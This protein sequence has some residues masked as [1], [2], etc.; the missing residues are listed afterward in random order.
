MEMHISDIIAIFLSGLGLLICFAVGFQL[1]FRKEG[2]RQTNLFLGLLLVLLAF[3]TTNGL[4]ATTGIMSTYR[5]LYF[6]PLVFTWS[7]G[8]L[9]YFFVRSKINPSFE[10]KRR[11]WIHFI[12]PMIQF[13]FY[14]SIGF[15]SYE[16]KSHIWSTLISPYL[17]FVEEGFLILLSMGYIIAIMRHLKHE[18]PKETWK[19]PVYRWLTKFSLYLFILLTI[20]VLYD[21][22]D[23]ILYHGYEF[24]LYNT[25]WIDFPLK[26]ADAG[27]SFFIGI[28]AYI[29][30]HQKFITPS[31]T[32]SVFE[33]LDQHFSILFEKDQL[34]RDPELN[35]DMV[36]K[37]L[38]IP[39]NTIS[40]YLS[41]RD[42]SFRGLINRF[43]VETFIDF[44]ESHT[45]DHLSMLGIAYE[46]GFNSKASFNRAFKDIKNQTL[47]EYF[48]NKNVS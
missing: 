11:D 29:Y 32:D 12:L 5:D 42:E 20:H 15:R 48:Q 9:F 28:N 40:K 1:L 35:L 31:R 30:Q 2:I 33:E 8:P 34:H 3:S 6:L 39:K 16:F 19:Q 25:N 4:L 10:F 27:L 7:I 44:V 24:N 14:L 45:M 22:A 36:S 17:Q 38:N 46:S 26:L 37:R 13:C 47:R 23:W 18:I 41:E 43:R 21:I